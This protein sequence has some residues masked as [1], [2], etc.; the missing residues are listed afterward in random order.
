M[1]VLSC[2]VIL[3]HL[4]DGKSVS[5]YWFK[6]NTGIVSWSS[7]EQSTNAFSTAEAEY[8]PI[9]SA[10]KESIWLRNMLGDLGFLQRTPAIIYEDNQSC[11]A[12]AKNSLIKSRT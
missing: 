12:I 5:G 10:V 2:I 4:G 7:K 3:M 9:S 8:V 6:V 11:I 1:K